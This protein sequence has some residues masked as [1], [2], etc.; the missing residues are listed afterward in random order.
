MANQ[1]REYQDEV[2]G[3]LK[4][5]VSRIDDSVD[6]L[7][8]L[9][10]RKCDKEVNRNNCPSPAIRSDYEIEQRT[11]LRPDVSRAAMEAALRKWHQKLQRKSGCTAIF[12]LPQVRLVVALQEDGVGTTRATV[13][14]SAKGEK[15]GQARET[16]GGR[17]D[18]QWQGWPTGGSGRGGG[19]DRANPDG[20]R[21][22]GAGCGFGDNGDV[23]WSKVGP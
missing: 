14:G 5:Y 16:A 3:D 4:T 2:R 19:P 1:F 8:Y 20:R 13:S 21:G 15:Q 9:E 23:C 12:L 6:I 11:I 22:T 17:H 18:Q 7:E 10:A